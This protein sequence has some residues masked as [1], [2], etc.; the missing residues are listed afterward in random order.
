MTTPML[1]KEKVPTT[2]LE[3]QYSK[4]A[5]ANPSTPTHP[6][7]SSPLWSRMRKNLLPV[8]FSA[9]LSCTLLLSSG[10]GIPATEP[11]LE[12]RLTVRAVPEFSDSEYRIDLAGLYAN[13]GPNGSKSSGAASG[14]VIASP[15]TCKF[16][17]FICIS[18]HVVTSSVAN[19]DYLY[20]PPTASVARANIPIV[21]P[22]SE[23]ALSFINI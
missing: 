15:S 12:K 20:A 10:R 16:E 9:V 3:L 22:G 7:P 6:S 21:I 8:I 17:D 19:P 18:W 2:Q 23:T 5:P 14:V 1:Y 4:S 13:I 11:A